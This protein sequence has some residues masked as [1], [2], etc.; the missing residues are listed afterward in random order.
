MKKAAI[1]LTLVFATA[2]LMSS[3]SKQACPAYSHQDTEPTEHVG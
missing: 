3:C 1:I 2:I